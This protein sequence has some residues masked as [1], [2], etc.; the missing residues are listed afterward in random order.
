MN[1]MT[2]APL[3]L[4]LAACS[5][6]APE[7]PADAPA[8]GVSDAAAAPVGA[9]R[10]EWICGEEPIETTT[11]EEGVQLT[12]RGETW[13]MQRRPAASGA[14]YQTGKT[15]FWEKGGKAIVEID[16]EAL[17]EC[18]LV[19]V[20]GPGARAAEAAPFVALGQEPGWRLEVTE[21]RIV[22][23]SDYGEKQRSYARPAP[24]LFPGRT[25]YRAMTADDDFAHVSIVDGPCYD[26][27]SGAAYPARVTVAMNEGMLEGCGGDRFAMV[28]G[29]WRVVSLDGR[30]VEGE[31]APTLRFESGRAS[32]FA[33]C[34]RWTGEARLTGEG[35]SLGP[36]AATKMACIGEGDEIERLFLELLG[37]VTNFEPRPDGAI[38][39][40]GGGRYIEARR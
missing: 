29:D 2:F 15:L 16:G 25:E 31:R 40:V 34:N 11:D 18:A 27:M 37:G 13:T 4:A 3:L 7:K 20:T 14:R 9:T 5:G 8:P 30:A 6:P 28:A 24:E 39:F 21:D 38:R 10:A 23:L 33:G 35:L 36:I 19:S 22:V 12:A 26:V 32:G 17:P 1:S